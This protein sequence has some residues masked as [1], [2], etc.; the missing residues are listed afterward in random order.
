MTQ[1]LYLATLL[2]ESKVNLVDNGLI[3]TGKINLVR[4]DNFDKIKYDC[5]VFISSWAISESNNYSQ[6]IVKGNNF[7]NSKH[8]I[9][10]HQKA[11]DRHKF[12]ESLN[13]YLLTN[14][15]ILIETPT[16]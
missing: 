2:G 5:D 9:L 10:I 8:G 15:N 6:D 3:A 4:L 12:A 1:Y 11:S 13:T 7:F 16:L 14:K